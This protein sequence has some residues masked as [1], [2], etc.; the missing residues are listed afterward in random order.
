M[1]DTSELKLETAPTDKRVPTQNQAKACYMCAIPHCPPAHSPATTPLLACWPPVSA[2]HPP[3][4]FTQSLH[5]TQ[6]LHPTRLCV[7]RLRCGASALSVATRGLVSSVALAVCACRYYNSWHQCKYDFGDEEPQCAKLKSWA[8][9]M[10]PSIWME[11]WEEQRENGTY[12]GPVPGE[13][14]GATAEH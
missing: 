1:A 6:P 2:G 14:K 7:P 11:K 4:H 3:L 12:A 8:Y 5:P 9:S 10:C 13:K